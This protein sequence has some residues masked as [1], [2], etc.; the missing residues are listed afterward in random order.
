MNEV[1]AALYDHLKL[2]TK[3]A[4]FDRLHVD[5]WMMLPGNFV[6]PKAEEHKTDKMSIWGYRTQGHRLFWRRLRRTL[7]LAAGGQARDRRH[8]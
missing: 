4:L 2:K 3:E 6:Y 1:Y 5:T 8:P 7:F